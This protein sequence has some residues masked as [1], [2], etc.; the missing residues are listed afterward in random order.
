VSDFFQKKTEGEP[1]LA[2]LV[3]AMNNTVGLPLL[4]V[5]EMFAARNELQE[6]AGTMG[7]ELY[8]GTDSTGDGDW[9][10]E[11]LQH[12]LFQ[13]L[14]EG[15]LVFQTS[16]FGTTADGTPTSNTPATING[17]A[18]KSDLLVELQFPTSEGTAGSYD[19]NGAGYHWRDLPVGKN[20]ERGHFVAVRNHL[21]YDSASPAEQSR[22]HPL[23]SY[24]HF[25]H[26]KN[27]Y[28]LAASHSERDN[29]AAGAV[30]ER[31]SGAA[32]GKEEDA[33]M[34]DDAEEAGDDEDDEEGSGDED[35]K[36]EGG[37]A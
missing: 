31:D 9:P 25:W 5:E 28:R 33:D 8:L 11:V 37:N 22:G 12:A 34:V 30:T 36:E 27:V 32:E 16:K 3:H 24:P 35:V 7:L 19:G 6:A 10:I 14:A 17:H 18:Q 23:L 26:A 21:V 29:K 20:G 4:T 15:N 1:A 2:S 13:K